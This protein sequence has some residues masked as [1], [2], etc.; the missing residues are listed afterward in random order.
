MD[1]IEQVA[2]EIQDEWDMSGLFSGIYEDFTRE[3]IR[4]LR[5]EIARPILHEFV[6]FLTS[7]TAH[8]D[9]DIGK[10]VNEW[11]AKEIKEE[12]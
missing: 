4:R 6:W 5:H 7:N 1:R 8:I 10:L 2:N 11:L 9:M 12:D 3:M